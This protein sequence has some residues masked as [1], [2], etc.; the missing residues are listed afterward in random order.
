M[1]IF[2]MNILNMAEIGK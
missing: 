2:I 1:S